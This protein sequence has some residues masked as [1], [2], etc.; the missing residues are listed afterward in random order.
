MKIYRCIVGVL[1][2]FFIAVAVMFIFS[3]ISE[4]GSDRKG[5]LVWRN[6]VS[7]VACMG[8]EGGDVTNHSI[9]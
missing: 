1:F 5:T 8:G 6:N 2:V 4:H 7:V 3:H 9:C